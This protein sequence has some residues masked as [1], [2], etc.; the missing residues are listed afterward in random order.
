MAAPRSVASKKSHAPFFR[1]VL[2][3]LEDRVVLSVTANFEWSMAKR[4]GIDQGRVTLNPAT[5]Q[6][7]RTLAP[8]GRIDIHND[9]TFVQATRFSV[10]FDASS[11][12]ASAGV[13]SY[14]WSIVGPTGTLS[15]TTQKPTFSLAQGLHTATLTVTAANGEVARQTQS[16]L[17]RDILIVS[18]GDSYASGEGTPDVRREF[19]ALNN[20]DRAL[21]ADSPFGAESH[22]SSN[23]AS[24]KAALA[25]ENADPHTSVT[26]VSVAVSGAQIRVM[27]DGR[28]D[29]VK[30]L[31]LT[32]VN[33]KE[34][35]N[36]GVTQLD[37]DRVR[38]TAGQLDQVKQIVG[39]RAIDSLTMSIG[40]NNVG[41]FP[42]FKELILGSDNPAGSAV[43][44]EFQG[45]IG[46]LPYLYSRLAAR[47]RDDL[48]V[49]A[50]R[51][52]INEYPDMTGDATGAVADSILGGV[53]PNV[54][55]VIDDPK[56]DH[57]ELQMIRDT[58]LRLLNAA[59]RSGAQTN[60]WNYVG[61]I[62]AA[63]RNHGVGAGSERWFNTEADSR[64]LQGPYSNLS[65]P[66]GIVAIAGAAA[67]TLLNPLGTLATG[68]RL[69]LVAGMSLAAGA[70]AWNVTTETILRTLDNISTEGLVHPN[71]EGTTQIAKFVRGAI[72]EKLYD[73]GDDSPTSL[74]TGITG[75]DSR[76][77][78]TSRLGPKANDT[79]LFKL[80]GYQN[81]TLTVSLDH[82][83]AR[84]TDAATA[85]AQTARMLTSLSLVNAS[86]VVVPLSSLA[87][88]ASGV[89]SFTIR[90]PATG[91]Y[92]LRVQKSI[93]PEQRYR[94]DIRH[95]N[96][97][98]IVGTGIGETYLLRPTQVVTPAVY[99][100]GALIVPAVT[101]NSPT[102]YDVVVN[103]AVRFQGAW[104]NLDTLTINGAAGND[105]F[106][107]S[108]N[109]PSSVK[110][111]LL[112]DAGNDTFKVNSGAVAVLDG[113][114]GFDVI[115]Y[116][117]ST[118]SVYVNLSTGI[119]TRVARLANVENATGGTGNDI[120]VGNALAN[121]LRGGAGVDLI[122]GGSGVDS[123]YGDAG[124][125]LVIPGNLGSSA[126][127]SSLRSIL[128]TWATTL[129]Y[130]TRKARVSALPV[131]IVRADTS[132]DRIF[133]VTSDDW[134]V[135][136]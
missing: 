3:S 96:T 14:R 69:A 87:V 38:N 34:G 122:V 133:G 113:G 98:N 33:G 108:A 88:S 89:T 45:S 99:R 2:E 135:A 5:G 126:F 17:V 129:P 121:I 22:R 25:I 67:A 77:T 42:I 78:I 49:P 102:S 74:N 109:V 68:G 112:G 85:A 7:V 12:T 4:F 71:N 16:V 28:A 40:G 21:W 83:I 62:E 120:L 118:A 115:D 8:D 48:R 92:Y 91:I 100:N 18:V 123:I 54:P 106:I 82:L 117:A 56:I 80:F 124:G 116:S 36:V 43:V 27:P 53:L 41:F 105:T 23:S 63:F 104:A 73:I 64:L 65:V 79:D 60:G 29:L 10:S 30:D 61:G 127:E 136:S 84:S 86:G 110:I 76:F 39:S 111:V 128:A 119:A 114:L 130:A 70:A 50:S 9:P 51:V 6:Y 95:A 26:F 58:G 24:A 11:S 19:N 90:V 20:Y 125:D 94:L 103:N 131:F 13:S 35:W 134:I 57:R 59:V 1:P 46:V 101:I 107:V 66:E 55:F 72:E 132:S 47:L 97:T 93:H 31:F 81:A 75:A 37:T 15:N 32:D 44:A 52:F